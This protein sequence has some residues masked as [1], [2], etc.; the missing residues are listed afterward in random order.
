MFKQKKI[1]VLGL[2]YVGLPLAVEFAKHFSVIGF[3]INA[4]RVEALN[5][6]ID[7]TNEINT[8]TLKNLLSEH[9]EKIDKGLYLSSISQ[10]LETANIF[11]ITVPTPID[12]YNS[13][14]L[15]PLLK[16]SE[17]VGKVLKHNDIVIYES[18][19]YPGCTEEECVPVL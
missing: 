12:R 14:N 17:T 16:A 4:K 15:E 3:D 5:A 6:G 8:E 1:A 2:G 19:V 18:T 7:N 10:D 9:V 13:P 11:I